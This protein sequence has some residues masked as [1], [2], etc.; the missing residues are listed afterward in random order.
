EIALN[1]GL[2]QPE[3]VWNA[4]MTQL[5]QQPQ[6][7]VLQEIGVD[8][9]ALD[10]LPQEMAERLCAIPVRACGEQV[11]LAV[12]ENNLQGVREALPERMRHR[13]QFVLADAA[14]IRLAIEESYG[15]LTP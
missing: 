5:A 13:V 8:C 6:R 1:W 14:E 2:C 4:W 3:H 12:S 7:I 10:A 9:Q 15:A 11:V